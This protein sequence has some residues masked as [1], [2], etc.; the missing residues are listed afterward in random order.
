MEQE[1]KVTLT[2]DA[3]PSVSYVAYQAEALRSRLVGT[4]AN[5]YS[6][7]RSV[8]IK[9]DADID[10]RD[11][12]LCFEVSPQEAL[13]IAPIHISA[14]ERHK[15]TVIDSF[16]KKIAATYLYDLTEKA[17]GSLSVVLET[18]AGEVIAKETASLFFLPIE[19]SAS[20]GWAERLFASFVTPHEPAVER[21]FSRAMEIKRE[22]TGSSSF[23][24]Y[25]A[26]DPNLV[27]EEVSAIFSALQECHIAYALP[28]A[29]FEKI[30]RVRLPSHVLGEGLATCLD[31]S[32]LFASV[33]EAAGLSPLL[34]MFKD[35]CYAGVWLEGDSPS[36]SVIDNSQLLLNAASKGFGKLL[37]IEAAFLRDSPDQLTFL[38][39]AETAYKAL[40]KGNGFV[41]ALD[42]ASARKEQ[43]LPV[44]SK[45]SFSD[46]S[47][48]FE[49]YPADASLRSDPSVDLSARRRLGEDY[50]GKKDRF[51]HWEDK[52]LDLNLRNRLIS[53]KTGQAGIEFLSPDPERLIAFLEQNAKISLVPQELIVEGLPNSPA[54]L[55][56]SPAFGAMGEE[57]FSRGSLLAVS[58]NNDPESGLKSLSRRSNTVVEESGCN[59]LFLVIGLIKHFDNPKAAERGT[60]ALY[61]PIFLL[62]ARLPRRKSG[63]YYTLEY[64]FEELQ[65]NRTAFEYFRETAGLSFDRLNP[66]P[67]L[68]SGQ[69]DVRLILNEIRSIIE[70]MRNWRVLENTS[71]LSLFNFAHFVMWN[72]LVT[73]RKEM[74]LHPG[75]RSFAGGELALR[76]PET[77]EEDEGLS[78]KDLAAPLSAD[79]SQIAAINA[80]LE[81]ESFILDGPPGTGKS[82]T[83]ANMI[84]NFLY[85][86]KKVLFIAEKE[87]ALDVVKKR[88]DDLHLGDFALKLANLSAAKADILSTYSR[89]LD[90]GPLSEAVGHNDKA[91]AVDKE[92]ER[93]QNVMDAL[94][95]EKG[96]FTSPYE[97]IVAYLDNEN[98]KNDVE[99]PVNYLEGLTAR[100]YREAL[101]ALEETAR[102]ASLFGSYARSPFKAYRDAEYSLAKREVLEKDLASLIVLADKLRLAAHNAM[103]HVH[104]STQSRRNTEAYL[105]LLSL[106][107]SG[108]PIDFARLADQ[109]YL[110]RSP[111]LLKGAALKRTLLSLERE[112]GGFWN[113]RALYIDAQREL[114]RATSIK[115]LPFFKRLKEKKDFLNGLKP[116]FTDVKT[117]RD[118][119]S[120]IEALSSLK[121][122]ADAKKAYASLDP[123]AQSILSREDLSSLEKIDAFERKVQM[124][125]KAADI[126]SRFSLKE[127][128]DVLQGFSELGEGLIYGEEN[129]TLSQSYDSFLAM[130]RS[131]SEKGFEIAYYDD[132]P[133]YFAYLATKL[134]DLSSSLGRLSEWTNFL[135]TLYHASELVPISFIEAYQNAKIPEKS[136]VSSYIADV[137]FAYLRVALPKRG[138]ASLTYTSLRSLISSYQDDIKEYQRLSIAATAERISAAFPRDAAHFAAST[139]AN[140]LSKLARN[141]GRGISL[142]N[143]FHAYKDLISRLTPCFMMS[144]AT[145]AQYLDPEDYHFDVV[146]FD[147]ASQIPTSEAMGAIFRADSF[148]IAGDKEQMP[149]SHY[150]ASDIGS[151]DDGL[152]FS[153]LDEDLESLLDDAL[154]LHLPR[155]RLIWHYRSRHESLIAFSNNRFYSN[156][157]LTFPSPQE[158]GLSLEFRKVKGVYE[159]GKGVNRAEAEA[160]VLEILRRLKS[161]ALRRFSI[162]VITFNEAQQNLVE[163]LLE[164]AL[165]KRGGLDASPGG[166]PIF[167]K[168]LENVQGDERDAILFSVGYGPDKNGVF[169]I[170]FGPLSQKKGE[171]RLN[172]AVS[173]ARESMTVFASFDPA[174]LRAQDAKN[175]GASYLKDFLLF[176]QNGF[177]A[178]PNRLGN[179]EDDLSVNVGHFLAE[180]LR[181]LGYEV[182]ENLGSS[183]FKIDCAVSLKENPDAYILG[184]LIDNRKA[185]STSPRDLYINETAVLKGLSWNLYSLFAVEYLD[186]R[187]EVLKSVV[188]AINLALRPKEEMDAPKREEAPELKKKAFLPSK[189]LKPYLAHRKEGLSFDDDLSQFLFYAVNVE[190]PLS[191]SL[192]D[193][194]I[195]K[196]FSLGRISANLRWRIA[197]AIDENGF[198]EEACGKY[199][200]Y[201]PRNYDPLAY[202]FWRKTDETVSERRLIDVGYIEIGNCAADILEEQGAMSIDDLAKAVATAFGYGVL[203]KTYSD[204]L[205]CGLRWNSSRRNGIYIDE[206]GKMSLR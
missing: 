197:A 172:V 20:G 46:G 92:R 84:V 34:V 125:A 146:I 162:G 184:I 33:L 115:D 137:S 15:A 69:I 65:L 143:L 156:S 54:Y 66:L 113:E 27:I 3:S 106:L 195:R 40:E 8:V 200:F 199:L 122:Y 177:S 124:T 163:D 96:D 11:L 133:D 31:F 153:S 111:V 174:D 7:L 186:H 6:F 60:G 32:L 101:G 10:F 73:H 138:V 136:L 159:R 104:I 112:V 78:A 71:A 148:V 102:L 21:V 116:Y 51:D 175:E 189:N 168:N 204:Y 180:D 58:R 36:A 37:L 134:R 87:V 28:P 97:A 47:D 42:I 176:A 55:E 26:H 131:L 119:D 35:H 25:L 141:G 196:A 173:R 120:T 192:L 29:S 108:A 202:R 103:R 72:D 57:G 107:K 24:G 53:Y 99:I 152:P 61:A 64:S 1:K 140:Q 23:E 206:D 9:N 52:L 63:P 38:S 86:G 100:S 94:H 82:Q 191:A 157:L 170:N 187:E 13:S 76:E 77:P 164:K 165:S 5:L 68:P 178:L 62:P 132:A 127:G 12:V 81:G 182:K 139:E 49:I 183:T 90:M 43:L 16:D 145:L 74:L 117:K 118:L 14:L 110:Q 30:Q 44:P 203:T 70:P 41:Y 193:E 105:S 160:V 142:R 123:Y 185:A 151:K 48:I 114:D 201:Y 2:I 39:A 205:K 93:L 130:E 167:V 198:V 18:A 109:A 88:L 89:L 91:L 155:R 56:L 150:F 190:Y 75:V 129:E 85:H 126:Y 128:E 4:G 50:A 144:P 181:K 121:S 45:S 179:R 169:S 17:V 59:P 95:E 135:K 147:E 83:I 161:P 19:Q 79:S 80:A 194:R 149:P 154:A 98:A 166:E 67:R 188:A 158:E 22:R 171:R